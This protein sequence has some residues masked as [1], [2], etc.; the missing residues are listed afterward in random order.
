MS[1][2][3]Q[4]SGGG[5]KSIQSGSS[6]G[7]ANRTVTISAVNT[8][9]TVVYSSCASGAYRFS[10]DPATAV[11]D[12]CYLLNSTTLQIVA[13]YRATGGGYSND[14]ATV[15]YQVVEYY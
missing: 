12:G 14:A 13:G 8:T 15:Y 1:T 2:L 5:I 7:T 3:S 6:S 9:K 10:T 4:F 11:I